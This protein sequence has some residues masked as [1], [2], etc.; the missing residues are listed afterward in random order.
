MKNTKKTKVSIY[1]LTAFVLMVLY[2]AF[3]LIRTIDVISDLPEKRLLLAFGY[4]VSLSA[5]VFVS[6]EAMIFAARGI[7]E[8]AKLK[9]NLPKRRAIPDIFFGWVGLFTLCLYIGVHSDIL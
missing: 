6:L 2:L 9:T 7:M 1:K 4:V 3:L 8:F 5:P